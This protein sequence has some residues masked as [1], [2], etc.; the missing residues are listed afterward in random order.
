MKLRGLSC[1]ITTCIVIFICSTAVYA[2]P[3]CAYLFDDRARLSTKY[4]LAK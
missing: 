2:Q 4:F 3:R 1:L